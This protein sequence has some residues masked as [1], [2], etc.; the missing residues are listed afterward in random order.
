MKRFKI[1]YRVKLKDWEVRYIII[2]AYTIEGAKAEFELWKRL[3]TD[4]NE[5]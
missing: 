1:T 4:I 5:I 2:R 3:I